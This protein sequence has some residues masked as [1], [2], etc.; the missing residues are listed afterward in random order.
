MNTTALPSR[1]R[2]LLVLDLLFWTAVAVSIVHYTDN[3]FA[4]ERFPQASSGPSPSRA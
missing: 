4:Y 3:Y 1:R 2:T